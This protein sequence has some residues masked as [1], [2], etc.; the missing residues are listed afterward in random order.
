MQGSLIVTVSIPVLVLT[1]ALQG[2]HQDS[3]FSDDETKALNT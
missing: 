3:H 1:V 2:A